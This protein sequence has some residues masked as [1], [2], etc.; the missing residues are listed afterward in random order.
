MQEMQGTRVRLMGEED[1]LEEGMANHSSIL[2]RKFHGQRNL[3]GYSPWG[4]NESDTTKGLSTHAHCL[5]R[6]HAHTHT[7]NTEDFSSAALE[8]VDR[9]NL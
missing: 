3:V 7:I 6:T 4:H 2:P 8:L 1:P 5:F 9:R